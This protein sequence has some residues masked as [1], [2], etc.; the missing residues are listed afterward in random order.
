[1]PLFFLKDR[2]QRLLEILTQI[3]VRA[4]AKERVGFENGK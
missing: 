1:M 2:M 3:R 4:A